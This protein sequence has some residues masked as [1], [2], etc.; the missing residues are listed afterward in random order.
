MDLDLLRA[1]LVRTMVPLLVGALTSLLPVL[2]G[3]EDVATLVGFAVSAVYYATFRIAET[4]YPWLGVFLGKR[5]VRGAPA[6]SPSGRP[7]VVPPGA[8]RSSGFAVGSR[9]DAEHLEVDCTDGTVAVTLGGRPLR[10]VDSVSWTTSPGGTPRVTLVLLDAT[11]S[12][13]PPS[14]AVTPSSAAAGAVDRP[15]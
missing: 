10:G 3:R 1:N 15:A 13:T 7:G 12:T 11:L 2:K 6:G 8:A 9:T 5:M 4:R 14:S